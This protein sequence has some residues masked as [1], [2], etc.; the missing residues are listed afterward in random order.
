MYKYNQ[1]NNG[2]L[3][4][5][6]MFTTRKEAREHLNLRVKEAKASNKNLKTY[7]QES[8]NFYSVKDLRLAADIKAEE[9]GL[10][11]LGDEEPAVY[12]E[13]TEMEEEEE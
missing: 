8:N 13:I 12:M 1:Y 7:Y 3:V 4:E 9:N 6:T 11:D 5:E 2:N 10:K